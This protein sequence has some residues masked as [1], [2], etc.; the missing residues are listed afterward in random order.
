MNNNLSINEIIKFEQEV[1]K[2]I[3]LLQKEICYKISQSIIKGVSK[4]NDNPNIITISFSNLDNTIL[5]A[6]YYN[7][8]AQANIV[9]AA[10]QSAK[11]MNAIQNKLKDMIENRCVVVNKVRET[12]NPATIKILT[13]YLNQFN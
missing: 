6:T 9:K 7:A 1:E 2:L 8:V 12:L 5:S 3:T 13:D 10:L 4:I 11:N